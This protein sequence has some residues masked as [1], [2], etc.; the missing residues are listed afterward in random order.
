MLFLIKFVF[1]FIS[2]LL[3]FAFHEFAHALTAYKFG[4]PTPKY[5]GRLT[6]NPFVHLDLIGAVVLMI[7]LFT[8]GGRVVVGWGKPVQYNSQAMKDPIL[9][10]GMVAFAGPF[11]NLIFA[12][13]AGLP[14]KLGLIPIPIIQ[15]ALTILAGVNIALFIFNLIPFPPLDG[16]KVL[17]IFVSSSLADKMCDWETRAGMV[18]MYCLMGFIFLFGKW[19]LSP[20][21]AFLMAIFVG[22]MPLQ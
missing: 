21:Y 7:S 22:R 15:D 9:H 2:I 3:A 6:L 16:W 13:I 8:T 4:D 19:I 20:P 18:P 10:G 12:I 14:V 17:Q 1:C 11:A 5:E